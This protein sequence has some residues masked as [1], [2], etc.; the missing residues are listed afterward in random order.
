[1]MED[2]QDR[3]ARRFGLYADTWARILIVV[4]IAA[5]FAGLNWEV[6][7]FIER[8]FDADLVLLKTLPASPRVVTTQVLIGLITATVV[9]VGVAI[10]AIVSYLFPKERAGS[11]PY[12]PP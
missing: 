3:R 7:R 11:G 2:A 5:I 12:G 4:V 9:Q 10:I 6:M 1:M 8:V